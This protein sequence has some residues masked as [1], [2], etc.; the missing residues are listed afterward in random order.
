MT[1]CADGY[2][3]NTGDGVCTRCNE[4]EIDELEAVE[5]EWCRAIFEHTGAKR[6]P[7]HADDTNLLLEA[8]ARGELRD[9]AF[10]EM[11][12]EQERDAEAQRLKD[13]EEV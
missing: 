8:A 6:C 10:D 5:C 12:D 3:S 2:Y 1:A 11:L 4:P 7:I 13:L 9:P